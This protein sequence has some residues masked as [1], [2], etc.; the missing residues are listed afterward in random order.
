MHESKIKV[1]KEKYEELCEDFEIL[2]A[3]NNI[4]ENPQLWL[5]YQ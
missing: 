1:E 2:K 5:Q 3:V 4:P